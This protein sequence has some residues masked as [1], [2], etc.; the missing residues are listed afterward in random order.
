MAED[1]S[2]IERIKEAYS[3]RKGVVPASR[4]SFF[5]ESHIRIL[6]TLEYFLLRGI[7]NSIGTKLDDCRVLDLGCGDGSHLIKFIGYGAKPSNLYGVDLLEDRI[8]KAKI[9]YGNLNFK[10]CDASKLPFADNY[11]DLVYQFTVFT[12]ILNPE[13]R[14]NVANE[15]LR[16]VKPEGAILWYDF[17]VDNPFNKDV[18]GVKRQELFELFPDCDIT[19]SRIVLAP[20]LQRLI[21]PWSSFICVFLESLRIFNTHY[22]AVIKKK[23]TQLKILKSID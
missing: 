22:F 13:M 18:K 10:C 5:S 19:I 17:F 21:A 20:P 2:E 12:S 8:E 7:K 9:S 11:F 6:Q 4:Y 1:H 14:S 15:M 16:V 23:K 3:R